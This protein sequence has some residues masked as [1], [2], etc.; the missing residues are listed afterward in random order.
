LYAV[1]TTPAK[2]QTLELASTA[3]PTTPLFF[4]KHKQTNSHARSAQDAK[5]AKGKPTKKHKREHAKI[6]SLPCPLRGIIA[7][8]TGIESWYASG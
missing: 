5:I 6:I 8:A 7:S 3:Q 4:A 1:P 2:W